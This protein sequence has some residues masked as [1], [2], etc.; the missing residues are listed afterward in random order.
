MTATPKPI[1]TPSAPE[2]HKYIEL[3]D[4]S[5]FYPETETTFNPVTIAH[6]GALTCRFGGQCR[7]FYSVAQHAVLVSH[8]MDYNGGNPFEGLMHD[9][10]ESFVLDMPTPIKKMLPDYTKLE[11][12]LCGRIRVWAGLPFEK[13]KDCELADKL[14]LFMEGYDLLPHR[15]TTFDDPTGLRKI[16]LSQREKF[17]LL[18]APL[19]WRAAKENWLYHFNRPMTV[20]KNFK[21]AK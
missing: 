5:V 8:I 13:S 16:A 18:L 19:D 2:P 6:S 20:W 17:L 4:G 15:G 3:S 9:A 7:D 1:S 11:K 12:D 14:A 10:S 21:V